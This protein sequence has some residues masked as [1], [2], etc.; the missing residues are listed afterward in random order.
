MMHDKTV[1]YCIGTG[2][3]AGY[4]RLPM[5][6]LFILIGALIVAALMLP[7]GSFSGTRAELTRPIVA[8][9]P[10]AGIMAIAPKGSGT[11]RVLFAR[12]GGMAL[13]R[14]IR[15][16]RGHVVTGLAVSADG[17]DFVIS[18]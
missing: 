15:L 5:R 8:Q 13:I 18:T 14:E 4:R 6:S 9:A 2:K 1:W 11:V 10:E 3:R 17:R 16:P 12:G 7:M